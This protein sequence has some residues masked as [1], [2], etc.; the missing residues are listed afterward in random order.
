MIIRNYTLWMIHLLSSSQMTIQHALL[1]YSYPPLS[2]H[3]PSRRYLML[4]QLKFYE[5]LLTRGGDHHLLLYGW[6]LDP[7]GLDKTYHVLV[8]LLSWHN[9]RLIILEIVRLSMNVR[10][11]PTATVHSFRLRRH[12]VLWMLSDWLLLSVLEGVYK[13]SSIICCLQVVLE[14]TFWKM[15][16]LVFLLVFWRFLVS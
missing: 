11:N 7:S 3:L 14:K 6:W 9:V 12:S 15:R 2:Y 16:E 1:P 13:F 10:G 4:I 8:W 5:W